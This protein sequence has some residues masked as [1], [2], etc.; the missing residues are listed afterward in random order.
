MGT[1]RIQR[2]KV[3]WTEH[4]RSLLGKIPDRELAQQMGI[5]LFIVAVERRR[6]GIAASMPWRII[7]WT[8]AML[9]RLGTAFD[10]VLAREWGVSGN[11]VSWKRQELGI[12]GL[13]EHRKGPAIAW[14]DEMVLDLSRLSLRA[15]AKQYGVSSHLVHLERRKRGISPA[16]PRGTGMP[17]EHQELLGTMADR[18]FAQRFGYD[19]AFVSSYRVR[20]AIASF[21]DRQTAFHWSPYRLRC[22]GRFSDAALARRWNIFKTRVIAKRQELGI[23]AWL[24]RAVWT[25]AMRAEVKALT[26]AEAS[27]RLGL[28]IHQI[29]DERRRLGHSIT[30]VRRFTPEE[31]AL[32]GTQSDAAIGALLGRTPGT[33]L[34]RRRRLGVPASP[35]KPSDRPT[36]ATVP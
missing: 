28:S 29:L 9:Q 32:L 11:I 30:P 15:F 27:K 19:L 20:N 16:T 7:T 4:H 23:P 5:S 10:A 36:A 2:K 22:L 24:A 6:L 13:N 21:R 18:E 14:T 3:Q 35:R 12:P 34:Q 17:E 8:P 33:I 1:S 26:P 25:D 31:D